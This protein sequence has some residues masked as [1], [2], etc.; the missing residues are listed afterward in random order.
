MNLASWHSFLFPV[1]QPLGHAYAGLMYVRAKVFEH[2][3]I[4][5]WRAQ[6]PC[7]S[8]GNI[9]WGGTGKTPVTAWLLTWAVRQG[10]RPA[11]LTRGYGGHPPHL[12]FQVQPDSSPRHCGDEPLLLAQTHG[13]ARVIVDPKRKRSGLWTETHDPPDLFIL[14]DGFQH[15]AVKRDIDMVLVNEHDLLTGWNRVLPAG[16]WRE[17]R[18]ALKRADVFVVNV[19]GSSLDRLFPAA[20]SRLSGFNRPIFFVRLRA[21]GLVNLMT[22]Q[23]TTHLDRAPYLLMTGI[24]N[25]MRVHATITDLVGYP[26]VGDALFSDHHAYTQ[27]DC[28]RVAQQAAEQG[29]QAIVCTPKDAVKLGFWKH[30]KVFVLETRPSFVARANTS[31]WLGPWLTQTLERQAARSL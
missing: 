3:L 5:A 25:P 19:T 13:K 11:V 1:W 15:L 20:Q 17:G 31:L 18:N 22:Q 28:L 26:P 10:M 29:A 23:R 30:P 12:P 9:S 16:T 6:T 27:E 2:G 8:V 7:L 4:P 24:A 14:D 21:T